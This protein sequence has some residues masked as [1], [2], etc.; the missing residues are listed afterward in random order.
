[1]KFESYD[2]MIGCQAIYRLSKKQWHCLLQREGKSYRQ[3][4]GVDLEPV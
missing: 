3:H 2:G 1:M 4:H